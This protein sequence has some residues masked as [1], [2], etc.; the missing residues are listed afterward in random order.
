MAKRPNDRGGHV[1]IARTERADINAASAGETGEYR[2]GFRL[3]ASRDV[4]KDLLHALL[5]KALMTSE[6]NDRREKR[7]AVNRTAAIADLGSRL[8]FGA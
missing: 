8:R 5:V 1:G 2:E 4:R 7:T 6:G 3:Q